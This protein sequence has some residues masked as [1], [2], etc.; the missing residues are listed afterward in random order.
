MNMRLLG[1]ACAL[2]LSCSVAAQAQISPFSGR[3]PRMDREDLA[4]MD[5]AAAPLFQGEAFTPGS[6]AKWSNPSSGWSGTITATGTVKVSGL[7]CRVLDYVF[8]IPK[9]PD[10]RSYTAKWC[11]TK[12]GTWKLG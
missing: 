3:G 5:K 7:N 12:D 2:V 1:V 4:L 11:R 10:N 8:D 9:R 6:T